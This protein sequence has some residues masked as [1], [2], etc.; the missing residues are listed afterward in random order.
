MILLTAILL[1]LLSGMVR[2]EL[3]K[4]HYRVL[5]VRTPG[6]VFLAFLAQF[7]IFQLSHAG[8]AVQDYWVPLIL[9]VGQILLLA[10]T[11]LNWKRPGFFL[12]ALGTGLNLAVLVFNHG[13]MPMKPDTITNLYPNV[14]TSSWSV[15]DHLWNSK[16]IVLT[17]E[18]T[19]L[20][21]LSDRFIIPKWSPYRVAFS[22]GDVILAAGAFWL[23]WSLGGKP[24]QYKEIK[25][26]QMEYTNPTVRKDGRK[27]YRK[28]IQPDP[29]RRGH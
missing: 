28:G 27:P 26:G 13:L 12:L 7:V 21:F 25:N 23:F 9:V 6:F 29:Y 19:H 14:P 16:N 15:G 5:Q 11:L 1:G 18:M 4:R 17:E 3:G 20:S 2:A 22:L 8:I 10:F 24:K